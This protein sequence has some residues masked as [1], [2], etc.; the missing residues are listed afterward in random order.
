MDAIDHIAQ[1]LTH[2]QVDGVDVLCCPEAIIGGLAHESDGE[3]PVDVALEVANGEL[4]ERLAPLMS[5]SVALIVGFTEKDEAGHIFGSAAVIADGHLAG[6][7]RKAYP[8]YR[9]VVQAGIELA[10]FQLGAATCG[11]MICNDVW[12]VEPARILAAAGAAVIFVPTHSGHLRDESMARRLRPRGEN[13]P[14][15]RAVENTTTVVVAD[16]AGR[17]G[18][19]FALGCSS[20]VDPDGVVLARSEPT[21]PGL[22]VADVEDQRRPADPRGWDGITNPEVAASFLELWHPKPG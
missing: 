9:T 22:I 6:I 18:D 20:I 19:R 16:V 4:A 8:G 13:L 17:Q 5:T 7:H 14:I 2:C 12:Y 11:V 3:S 10:T 21:R 1:Q 15:A